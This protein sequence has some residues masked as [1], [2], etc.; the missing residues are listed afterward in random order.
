MAVIRKILIAGRGE[1]VPRIISTCREM[2]ILTVTIHSSFDKNLPQVTFAD[3]SIPLYEEGK[4]ETLA[5]TYL[6]AEKIISIAKTVHADAIHPCY[7]LLSENA[8]FAQKVLDAGLV[9]IGPSPA[10]MRL[11]GN[12]VSAKAFAKSLGIDVIESVEG[13]STGD[14]PLII[15]AANGGG[16]RGMRIVREKDS[17]KENL[18]SAIREAKASFNDDTVLVERFIEAPRHVEVQIMG[19]VHGN[20]VHFFERDCSIQRRHQKLIE[21]SPSPSISEQ[22]R[23]RILSWAVTLARKAS[24]TNAGTVE[25]IIDRQG[26]P[27]FMEVN[28]RLQ[29]EHPVTEMV[30]GFDLVK[31]QILL[32]QGLPLPLVQND[33]SLRGHAIEVRVCAENPAKEF[34]PAGGRLVHLT[35]PTGAQ[36]RF[37]NGYAS[38]NDVSLQ[39]DSMLAKIVALAPTRDES[40]SKLSKALAETRLTGI[41]TNRSFLKNILAHQ[42]FKCGKA[43]TSFVE[44]NLETLTMSSN[45]LHEDACLVAA[46]LFVKK[47]GKSI[48]SGSLKVAVSDPWETL[49]SFRNV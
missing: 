24:Y 31:L 15:K 39:Y 23:D 12:K 18:E 13:H 41:Q 49:S 40:I 28:T 19:D 38:G 4:P 7:G 14:F 45:S 22:T 46:M 26:R 25:F 2:G 47:Q 30:T 9:F 1:I 17:L 34:I 29:V 32:S 11:L 6:D 43:D 36:I 35:A 3:E 21:E 27:Y 33:I 20:V 5:S 16:G 8:D 37:E 48:E 42:V 44:N 10:T